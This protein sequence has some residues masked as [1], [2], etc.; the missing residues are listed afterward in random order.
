MNE[1]NINCYYHPKRSAITKCEACQKTICVECK[2]VYQQRHM[3]SSYAGGRHHHHSYYTRHELCP[4][5]YYDRRIRTIKSPMKYCFVLFGL[6]FTIVAISMV[7]HSLEFVSAWNGPSSMPG[8]DIFPVFASIFVIVGVGLMIFGIINIITG[9]KRVDNLEIKKQAF[10]ANLSSVEPKQ[11]MIQVTKRASLKN[12]YPYCG[13]E[14]S[15]E[16]KICDKCG[17]DLEK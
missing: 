14:I 1:S 12:Y 6:I 17:I 15:L 8:P 2:M 7:S 13:D 4:P 16:E 5:C 10:L 9:P 3:Y 11:P